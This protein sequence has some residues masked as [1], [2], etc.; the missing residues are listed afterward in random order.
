MENLVDNATMFKLS[1][2][3]FILTTKDGNKDTGCVINTVIPA[4]AGI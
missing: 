3:L 1:Y 4:K 2:G